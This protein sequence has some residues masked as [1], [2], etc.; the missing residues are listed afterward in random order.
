MSQNPNIS[1]TEAYKKAFYKNTAVRKV[2]KTVDANLV[3][4][5][6]T[7]NKTE[8]RPDF[9]V[10]NGQRLNIAGVK[11]TQNTM[12]AQAK[13]LRASNIRKKKEENIRVRNLAQKYLVSENFIRSVDV[14]ENKV[15]AERQRMNTDKRQQLLKSYLNIQTSPTN[16]QERSALKSIMNRES[17]KYANMY[18]KTA[19]KQME[20]ALSQILR[21]K[22]TDEIFFLDPDTDKKNITTILN[23]LYGI[24][25]QRTTTTLKKLSTLSQDEKNRFE[26]DA[27]R[28]DAGAMNKAKRV[29]ELRKKIR[30]IK[31]LTSADI[32][33]YTT[34]AGRKPEQLEKVL[35]IATAASEL[36]KTG[37]QSKLAFS[38]GQLGRSIR[39]KTLNQVVMYINTVK[40]EVEE[41]V[42]RQ[43]LDALKKEVSNTYK[44]PNMKKKIQNASSSAEVMQL[45]NNNPSEKAQISSLVHLSSQRK[46]ALLKELNTGNYVNVLQ[47]AKNENSKT[48]M[49]K[50]EIE[51]ARGEITTLQH[52]SPSRKRQFIK[53][54]TTTNINDVLMRAIRED[55]MTS[56]QYKSEA[57]A[58]RSNLIKEPYGPGFKNRL[59]ELVASANAKGKVKANAEAERK[60]VE[61]NRKEAERKAA[62]NSKEAERKA[63]AERKEAERKVAAEKKEAERKAAAERKKAVANSK[64]AERKAAAEK[65]EAERKAAAERKKAVAN[66]KEA[67]R[68]AAAEKKEAEMKKA[69]ANRKEAERK[70]VANSKEAERKK[71][72]AS[73]KDAERKAAVAAAAAAAAAAK[74][75]QNAGNNEF[76]NARGYLSRSSS[77]ASQKSFK[78]VAENYNDKSRKAAEAVNR[79][80]RRG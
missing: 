9:L 4:S 17:K 43:R 7:N 55:A 50:A 58:L 16:V 78:S 6:L 34:I 60:K 49:K 69:E 31:G 80:A 77:M 76:K 32:K 52:L 35:L 59:K 24:N 46:S 14:N 19:P 28:G 47:R 64:E 38:E 30:K 1:N 10:M 12:K 3:N 37:A 27:I 45:R 33:N 20:L 68:K 25:R 79:A 39:N 53:E 22:G 71:A 5:F 23:K 74:A 63:A 70:A 54:L 21:K 75:K 36:A 72:A 61:A 8:V 41:N 29:D 67:E 65:K 13:E 62:A 51:A 40:K 15:R 42:Q 48:Q 73:R 2:K 44:N 57:N 18:G 66:S 11:K 26:R 56:L